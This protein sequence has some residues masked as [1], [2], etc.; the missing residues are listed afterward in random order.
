[1]INSNILLGEQNMEL[2]VYTK[3]VSLGRQKCLLGSAFLRHTL[4]HR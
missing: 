3:I 4:L 2:K 1:M